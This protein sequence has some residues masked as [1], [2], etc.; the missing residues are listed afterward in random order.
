MHDVEDRDLTGARWLRSNLR[1][2]VLQV[3]SF[4]N[5]QQ[6]SSPH[7]RERAWKST[8]A[9]PCTFVATRDLTALFLCLIETQRMIGLDNDRE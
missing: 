7:L 1:W 3:S 2:M 8:L 5:L 4:T 9:S 6:S